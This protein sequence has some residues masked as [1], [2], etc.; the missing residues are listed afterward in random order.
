MWVCAEWFVLDA[1]VVI[2]WGKGTH[3]PPPGHETWD[4]TGHGYQARSP[5][6]TGMLSCFTFTLTKIQGEIT[7]IW[8]CKLGNNGNIVIH[9]HCWKA[10][11]NFIYFLWLARSC[12]MRP[13]NPRGFFS[14]FRNRLTLCALASVKF[15]LCHGKYIASIGQNPL[16]KF[17][18]FSSH[19]LHTAYIKC[20]RVYYELRHVCLHGKW[21]HFGEALEFLSKTLNKQFICSQQINTFNQ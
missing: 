18:S 4:T 20:N 11:I 5:H 2:L 21:R 8:K 1:W 16:M 15:N 10:G 7:I 12:A 14:A 6:P 13:G 9:V 3:T 17:H 19:T